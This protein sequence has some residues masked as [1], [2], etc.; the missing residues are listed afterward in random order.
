[1]PMQGT[2]REW[3][4]DMLRQLEQLK[5]LCERVEWLTARDSVVCPRCAARE[6]KTYTL[7][8]ARG[9]LE[10]EFCRPGDPDDRCRCTFL[11]VIE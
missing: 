9:E 11:P 7:A 3:R 8:E 4:E 10:G 6:G 1:M 5:G 2:V